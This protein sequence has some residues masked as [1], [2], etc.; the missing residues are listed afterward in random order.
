M[1]P[2]Y[3]CFVNH[4]PIALNAQI[5]AQISEGSACSYVCCTFQKVLH[6][7]NYVCCTVSDNDVEVIFVIMH[8]FDKTHP[9][10]EITVQNK[11]SLCSLQM[12][13]RALNLLSHPLSCSR[14]A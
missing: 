12:T 14:I 13:W 5:K 1:T 2:N 10:G 11:L 3:D 6:V 4:K 7:Y 9:S 8:A